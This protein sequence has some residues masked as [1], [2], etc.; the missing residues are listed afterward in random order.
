VRT[1]EKYK[2]DVHVF[3]AELFVL[4]RMMCIAIS[5]RSICLAASWP[6]LCTSSPRWR[7]F[8]SFL[9]RVVC[10]QSQGKQRRVKARGS[11]NMRSSGA[12]VLVR[13]THLFASTSFS[14]SLQ[15]ARSWTA[16]CITTRIEQQ[17]ESMKRFVIEPANQQLANTA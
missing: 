10:L 17:Q 1:I 3:A 4:L 14:R 16:P 8:S 2:E 11:G 6:L 9:R 5:R 15:Y 7:I 12:V 13:K